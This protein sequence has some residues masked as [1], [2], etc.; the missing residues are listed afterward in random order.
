MYFAGRLVTAS[1]VPGEVAFAAVVAAVAARETA[2][3]GGVTAFKAVWAGFLEALKRSMAYPPNLKPFA[4]F[5]KVSQKC[6]SMDKILVGQTAGRKDFFPHGRF[7]ML[8]RLID[9][10]ISRRL[11]S[12]SQRPSMVYRIWDI[13]CPDR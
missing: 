2:C 1:N 3:A 9:R 11:R 8:N 13:S 10:N 12:I 7:L 6:A 4:N 5:S